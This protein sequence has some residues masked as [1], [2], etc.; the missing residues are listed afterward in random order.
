[1]DYLIFIFVVAV[2]IVASISDFRKREV[3]D[4]L[5]YILIGGSALL[6]LSYSAIYSTVS[7]LIYLPLSVLL[8]SGFSYFMYR[9]G[10]WGGGDV[11]LLFG[12]SLVFTSIGLFSDK[13]FVALFIN[14]L[15]FG[16]IYGLFGTIILG[17]VKIR[18]LRHYFKPYDIPFLISMIVVIILSAIL[19]PV[20]LNIFIV[21][22][23]F[24]LFSMRFVL[25]VANNLMYVKEKVEKLTEGDWLAE[26]PKDSRNRSIVPE[27]STGLTL[28]D[29]KK[30]KSSNIKEVMIKIGLPFVPGILLAVI[31]TILFGNPLLQ[32]LSSFYI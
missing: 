18:K 6:V 25:L 7:N 1:M 14:I 20:P 2:L 26:A 13:S 22:A 12:L 5:S 27:R 19:I 21:I 23:A 29:I 30:L 32:I 4:S 3:P 17:L 9:I 11:K 24:M 16:G 15:L 10:Q 31:I 8:I 28:E